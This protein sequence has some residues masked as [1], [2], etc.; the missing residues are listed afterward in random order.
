MFAAEVLFPLLTK[1]ITVGCPTGHQTVHVCHARDNYHLVPNHGNH[2][3]AYIE[4]LLPGYV[5]F[6]KILGNSDIQGNNIFCSCGCMR[7]E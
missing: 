6:V 4:L 7:S 1:S 2:V 5:T 3:L